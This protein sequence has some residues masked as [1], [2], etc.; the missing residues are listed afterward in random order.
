MERP[1]HDPDRTLDYSTLSK[2]PSIEKESERNR[3]EQVENYNL[4]TFGDRRPYLADV[5]RFAAAVGV[6]VLIG[7]LLPRPIGRI[8]SEI[9][10]VGF[11]IWWRVRQIR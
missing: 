9:F 8:A 6:A 1:T 5:L 2:A 10:M 11:V 7:V 3:R 4:T